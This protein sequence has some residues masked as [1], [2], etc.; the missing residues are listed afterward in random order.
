MS[1]VKTLEIKDFPF[2]T[3]DS[4]EDQAIP[5][6]A[7]SASKNWLTLGDRIELRRGIALIGTE[8]TGSG[9][10]QGTG[11]AECAD[12]TQI[13][14]RKRSRKLE[15]YDESTSDWV[16]VGTDLFPAAAAN[17]YAAFANYASLAGN[18][19]LVCSPNAG[20]FKIMCANPG[21]YTDLTDGSKN[22]QG[23]IKIK[24]NRMFLWGRTKD[25]TG[26]YGSYIDAQNYT[27]V[28]AEA[29]GS[30]DGS[31][32][33]FTGTLAFKAAGSTRTCF[34]ITIT[35][36]TET[37]TDDYNGNLVGSAGGTGTINYTTGD[38]SITFNAAPSLGTNN[39]T[40]DYQWEDSNNQGITDFTK[41]ATRLAGEGFIFR[42]DDG[43]GALQ[44]VLS[45]GDVE[46]C[47]HETKTWALTLTADDTQATNL[48]Y[49]D[50]VGIPNWQAACETGFGIYYIDYTDQSDPQF[51]LLT[52]NQIGTQV[53]PVSIS[54]AR[55]RAGELIGMNLSDYRFDKAVVREWGDYVVF[56][57]RYKD[58]TKNDTLITYNKIN[59]ALD[60]HDLSASGVAIY[61]GTLVAGDSVSDN[62]YVFFSGFDDDESLIDNA[63]EGNL[64]GFGTDYL[65][66]VRKLIV[67][68]RIQ[69]AQSFDIYCTDDNGAYALVG[70]ISGDGTYVDAG[71]PYL[72]GTETLGSHVVGDG[73]DGVN[74]FNYQHVLSLQTDKFQ[75]RKIK[76]VATGLGYLSINMYKW[77]DV[78]LYA[79][80]TLMKYR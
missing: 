12:G 45:Y 54:K 5:D 22:F 48:I 50:R 11:V 26:L 47:M 52:L 2:G 62:S 58:S 14:F 76:F 55:K 37:F 73:G 9:E 42:Q 27:A 72:V 16:E 67:Q 4:V 51:R 31:T 33:T 53:I 75:K 34:G 28:S 59:G 43:G 39:I 65:K 74:A 36:G 25:K 24:Q 78:R 30:G 63:W 21:D 70:S 10:I 57:C 44:N 15:Y 7:A 41:S 61:N 8:H 32:T 13:H 77:F 68:G 66:K 23:Y 29:V 18:Q 38:F 3:I 19:L 40:S 60:K 80:R 46:Y 49:R 1:D 56:A 17:D 64:T 35:D 71:N 6:G 69:A 79:K 20:P